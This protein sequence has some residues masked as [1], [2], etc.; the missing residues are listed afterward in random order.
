MKKK[1][2]IIICA[3]AAL[4]LGIVL[5]AGILSGPKITASDSSEKF[6]ESST[7]DSDWSAADT[8][9]IVIENENFSLNLD[10]ETTHFTVTHKSSGKTYSSVPR[11]NTEYEARYLSEVILTY[12]DSNSKNASMTSYENSVEG[13]SYEIKTDGNAI[14]VYYSIRK[15][16]K[17]IFVPEVVGQETFEEKILT[18]LESGPKRRLKGFYTLYESDGSDTATKE[19]KEKY[20]ALEKEN[21]YILSSKV[22]EHNYSE[23][24]GYMESAGYDSA[25]YMEELEAL[26][27]D[28][29][30]SESMS[31]G[32]VIPVEYTLNEDGFTAM[33]L[34]DK[35]TSDSG[36]YKLTNVALL[37]Y[38]A[39]IG[40]T[41]NGWMLVPD[42]SGAVIE[43][44]EKA[45]VT[46]SQKLWGTDRAVESSVKSN[47]M[48]NAG[49]PV[50]GFHSGDKA[51]LAEVSGGAAAASI[52]AEVFGNE[53]LQSHIY[54]AF[55]VLAFDTSDIGEVRNQATFN[56]YAKE[57]IAEFPKVHYSLFAESDTTYSDMAN[58]YREVLIQNGL[59]GERLKATG[60]I[61]V[62]MDFTG[63]ETTEQSVLGISIKTE[64][65]L[66]SLQ[67]IQKTVEEFES[68]GLNEMNIRLKAYGN[69]GIYNTLSAGF[70]LNGCMGDMKELDA[71][72]Q[73]ML[74]TG[75]RL[76]LENSMSTV[77]ATGGSFKKMTHAVRSL[78]KTVIT[79]FDYDLVARTKSEAALGYYL[80]SPAYFNSLTDHFIEGLAKKSGDASAYGYSWS[81][82]GSSL[83][84]DFRQSDAYDRTQS[85]HAANEA[86]KTAGETFEGIITDGSN[87]Y[88]L[89][90]VTALLNIPLMDSQLSCES[91]SVPFYQMVLHG[92]IDYAG[93]PLNTGADVEKAYLASVESGASLYYSFYTSEDE[94]LKKT[95]AGT[96]IYPT[97]ASASYDVAEQQYSEYE[98]LFAGL[99]DQTIIEH[100]RT[101]DRVFVTTYENGVRIAVNYS[102]TDILEEGVTV[103]ANGYA[104]IERSE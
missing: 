49:L 7:D 92:Y 77:Y 67:D 81:D 20:P 30:Q 9:S 27:L 18:K 91:Y 88:A 103:P 62:Y 57:Y 34:T 46:Y 52:S 87:A 11:D 84:S 38:F 28:G 89:P 73:K 39:S 95:D 78:K 93:A 5:L 86:V 100:E 25:T 68:R 15:S 41:E 23:I 85:V 6:R 63:Y 40:S 43:L 37:P 59:L 53:Y 24:S 1:I 50:F 76:Y 94:V 82:Y 90:Y 32:F 97:L 74:S 98:T 36:S 80:I 58:H 4:L 16:K 65:V 83:W 22:E 70:E 13:Q 12:Y 54:A 21:L 14:R 66:S 101:A 51:F 55:D 79:A 102:E 64:A 61:P 48:Q 42:G 69:N 19:M 96:L 31:A 60:T 56:L 26:G 47:I 71:L 8:G 10:S 104:V 35:I 72:A 2:I 45:G 75:G 99:R 3:A 44:G 33:V 17:Q 29:S